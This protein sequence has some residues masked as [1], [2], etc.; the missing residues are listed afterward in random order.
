MKIIQI[1]KK[2]CRYI[3][4]GEIINVDLDI[5]N[6]KENYK[7]VTEIYDFTVEVS[8]TSEIFLGHNLRYGVRTIYYTEL[9]RVSFTYIV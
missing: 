7:S 6:E 4:F 3:F 2:V 8:E 9:L 1:H 5:I